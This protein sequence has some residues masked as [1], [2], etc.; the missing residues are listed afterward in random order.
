MPLGKITSPPEK[1]YTCRRNPSFSFLKS[2]YDLTT[3][4]VLIVIEI[5]DMPLSVPSKKWYSTNVS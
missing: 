3:F 4:I 1:E 2:T 5:N